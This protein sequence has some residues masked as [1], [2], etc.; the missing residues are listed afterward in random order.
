V[1]KDFWDFLRV[2]RLPRRAK[3]L[4]GIQGTRTD[5]VCCVGQWLKSSV[6]KLSDN[7]RRPRFGVL[8]AVSRRPEVPFRCLSCHP[9]QPLKGAEAIYQTVSGRV[10]L[11]S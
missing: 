5:A 8:G 2:G 11:R 6:E 3:S 10:I 1:R 9:K 4:A 7:S